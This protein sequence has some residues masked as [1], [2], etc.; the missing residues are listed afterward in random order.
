MNRQTRG[1]RPLPVD[2]A[3]AGAAIVLAGGI[4]YF[5]LAPMC[6]ADAELRRARTS[7]EDVQ[8]RVDAMSARQTHMRGALDSARQL[9]S[10]RVSAT[11]P[12]P[13]ALLERMTAACAGRGIRVERLE[14]RE[15]SDGRSELVLS[16]VG[17]F[18]DFCALLRDI[19]GQSMLVQVTDWNAQAGASAAE[20]RLEWTV[21]VHA[22]PLTP[23]AE[24]AVNGKST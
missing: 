23:G 14:P 22:P 5:A 7:I 1:W 18:V 24:K 6:H 17:R 21:R 19:E 3:G 13:A 11:V 15:T 16:G 10:S 20:T 9:M 8:S 2:F 12:N 4:W